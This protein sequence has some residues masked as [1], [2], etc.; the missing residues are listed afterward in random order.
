MAL[1]ESGS[2]SSGGG[3]GGSGNGNS[4]S[5]NGNSGSGNGDSYTCE[6]SGT[7]IIQKSGAEP[8]RSVFVLAMGGLTVVWAA[9]LY[10]IVVR[11][12]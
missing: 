1:Q 5:G 9:W 8:G 6:G 3:S 7:C 4:G 11:V 2:G 12:I 10:V